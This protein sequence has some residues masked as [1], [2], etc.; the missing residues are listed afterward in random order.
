MIKQLLKMLIGMTWIFSEID[1]PLGTSNGRLSILAS[2]GQAGKASEKINGGDDG[3]LTTPDDLHKGGYLSTYSLVSNWLTKSPA[4]AKIE[5]SD[6][7]NHYTNTYRLY[8]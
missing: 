6:S 8:V 5:A 1:T 2:L 7:L 4:I 3:A